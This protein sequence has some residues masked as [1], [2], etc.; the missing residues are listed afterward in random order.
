MLLFTRG[1]G[2]AWGHD[3]LQGLDA[4]LLLTAIGAE[5]PLAEIYGGLTVEPD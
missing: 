5:L 1:A 3:E 2:G 4:A